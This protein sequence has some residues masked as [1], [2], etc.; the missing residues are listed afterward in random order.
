MRNMD[1]MKKERKE[2]AY[3]AKYVSILNEI[4]DKQ[5]GNDRMQISPLL[6]VNSGRKKE[7]HV[8]NFISYKNNQIQQLGLQF[9]VACYI[10]WRRR[11]V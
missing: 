11:I 7:G 3:F 6:E 9:C 4:A 8:V 5:V 1:P 10:L 2:Q